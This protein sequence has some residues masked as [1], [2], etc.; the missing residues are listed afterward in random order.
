VVV[1]AVPLIVT[2]YLADLAVVPD[3]DILALEQV[4]RVIPLALL[5][6]KATAAVMQ[7]LIRVLR[8]FQVA[9]AVRVPAETQVPYLVVLGQVAMEPRLQLQDLA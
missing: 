3:L 4:D 7:F 5:H 1:V 2:V 8:L 9:A 6:R